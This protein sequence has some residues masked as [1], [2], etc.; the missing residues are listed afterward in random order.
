M[1]AR[2]EFR[3]RS[4]IPGFGLSLG[5]TLSYATLIVFIPLTGIF[6]KSAGLGLDGFLA[7]AFDARALAAYRVSFGCAILA[8]LL[9]AVFGFIVA[10]VLVR[11]E[12]PLKRLIDSAVD[13]P[14]ALPTAVSGIALT[15]IFAPNGWIGALF[16]P[17]GIKTAFSLTGITIALTFIG[18]PFVVRTVQPV[19]ADLDRQYEEAALSLGASKLQI[20]LRIIL[21][22]SGPALLIG[23]AL[24]F[25]RGVGEYGSVIF[26]AGNMP[27]KTEIAA[28]LIVTKL[29]QFDYGGAAAIGAGMLMISFVLLFALNAL[30]RRFLRGMA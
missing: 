21:P 19:L 18:L 12:F 3:R 13:L 11:Y 6:I 27:Y 26:I 23:A 28:L 1:S 8:A 17:L 10:W 29:E 9:N 2:F 30:Q 16:A 20:F 14:F 15:A 25:A 7:A 22:E 24:A 5:F 4:V